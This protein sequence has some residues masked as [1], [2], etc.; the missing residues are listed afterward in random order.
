MIISH[1]SFFLHGCFSIICNQVSVWFKLQNIGDLQWTKT[2][3]PSSQY[4]KPFARF[5]PRNTEVFATVLLDAYCWIFHIEYSSLGIN[6]D[7]LLLNDWHF[8][9]ASDLERA[10]EMIEIQ[11]CPRT[12]SKPLGQTKTSIFEIW[13]RKNCFFYKVEY[14]GNSYPEMHTNNGRFQSSRHWSSC[15]NLLTSTTCYKSTMRS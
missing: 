8:A 2:L 14:L 9:D 6:K 4:Q 15:W 12:Q 1:Y 5:I 11:P 10:S 7:P 13:I 3:V